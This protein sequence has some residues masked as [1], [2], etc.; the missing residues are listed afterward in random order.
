MSKL[1]NC[2]IEAQIQ[3]LRAG[4]ALAS[5]RG[6]RAGIRRRQRRLDAYLE[7]LA[8]RRAAGLD[9]GAEIQA[10]RLGERG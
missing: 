6:D 2:Q 3:G 8:E 9:P 7:E 4:I 10:V 5:A 1:S